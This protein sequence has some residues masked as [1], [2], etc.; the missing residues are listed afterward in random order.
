LVLFIIMEKSMAQVTTTKR[1]KE[2]VYGEIE[3]LLAGTFK[4]VSPRQTYV[5]DLNRRLSNYPTALPEIVSPRLPRDT[6]GVVLVVIMGTALLIL[7]V[8]AMI[9]LIA[10]LTSYISMRSQTG[11]RELGVSGRE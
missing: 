6:A 8:R 3:N 5:K 11:G 7:G 9:P 4:P 1:K 2:E 10:S